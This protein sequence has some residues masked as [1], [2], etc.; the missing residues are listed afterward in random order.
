M[1][2]TSSPYLPCTTEQ[3]GVSVSLFTR[4]L[5]GVSFPSHSFSF[6]NNIPSLGTGGG[7][8]PSCTKAVQLVLAG[9]S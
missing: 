2:H 1:K 3:L 5:I 4:E 6:N 9:L 7:E 8:Q